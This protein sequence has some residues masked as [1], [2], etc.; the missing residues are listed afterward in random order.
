VFNEATYQ[1]HISNAIMFPAEIL[2]SIWKDNIKMDLKRHVVK[3]SILN[4]HRIV[5]NGMLL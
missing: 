1:K 2:I 3:R 5:S 4:S